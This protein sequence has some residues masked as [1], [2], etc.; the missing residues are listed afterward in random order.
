MLKDIEKLQLLDKTGL[1]VK[2]ALSDV[3]ICQTVN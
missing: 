1:I 2:T 3:D